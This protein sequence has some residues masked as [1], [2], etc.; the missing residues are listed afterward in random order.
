MVNIP[1]KAEK[2]LWGTTAGWTDA[3]TEVKKRMNPEERIDTKEK[4]YNQL[5]SSIFEQAGERPRTGHLS[6]HKE[7]ETVNNLNSEKRRINHMYSDIN[8]RELGVKQI[9]L[10]GKRAK[11]TQG[12]DFS[13]VSDWRSS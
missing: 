7:N 11:A 13:S 6:L 5:E 2:S 9:D 8:G 12:S 4:K 3:N 1:H 10:E